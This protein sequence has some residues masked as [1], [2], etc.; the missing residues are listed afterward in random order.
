MK[1]LILFL[2]ASLILVAASEAHPLGVFSINTYS[3]LS[4]D[5]KN[6][7]VRYV[8]DIAEIP[9]LREIDL[10]DTNH[11]NVI[12]DSERNIYL[13]A[14]IKELGSGIHLILNQNEKSLTVNESEISFTP[15]QGDLKT[16][17]LSMRFVADMGTTDKTQAL[18]YVDDNFKESR[19]WKE[20][21]IQAGNNVVIEKSSV[22]DKDITNELRSYPAAMLEHPVHVFEADASFTQGQSRSVEAS[23][24]ETISQKAG[25]GFAE[26]ISTKD[27]SLPVMLVSLLIAFALGAG[28]AL[29]PGHGKTIVAAYLVGSRGT[30][31]H[32]AF[33]G[34]TVTATHTLGVFAM[35][36]IALFAS[37]YILSETLFPWLSLI[38]GLIVVGIG[39][40]LFAKRFTAARSDKSEH[41]HE[42]NHDHSH[43]HGSHSHLPP[44][45]DGSRITWKNLLALGISGG[46]L[47]CPSAVVVL[48]SAIAIGRIGFGLALIVAFSLGLASV[49]TGIGMLMVHARHYF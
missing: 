47:P 43:A 14:Q 22:S 3:R 7:E 39:A 34:F 26:L 11:N 37:K 32:A 23:T 21:V 33:L 48:L 2:V 8:V 20:I 42:H 19:G 38:S 44:G 5:T 29:T 15:G 25:D 36:L 9:S 10:M 24:L 4:I 27:L 13:K 17:R 31:K 45:T 28:H 40:S 1:N 49:L 46:L 12:D 18:H 30:T 41:E 16:I 35:G 6:I